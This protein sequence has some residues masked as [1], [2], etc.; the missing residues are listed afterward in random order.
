MR[1]IIFIA[2]LLPFFAT[3]QKQDAFVKLID[4]NGKQINGDAMVKGFEKTMQASST[5]SG[6]KNNIQFS[7]TMN[8]TGAAADLKK[9]MANGE[10]LMTGQ[11]TLL[12][13]VGGGGAPRPT[14]IIKMKKI[15]VISCTESMGCNN[16]ITTNC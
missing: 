11:V 14:Y 9:A 5:S 1:K 12:Q 2:V 13:L 6:G 16:T 3:A 4:V 10:L 15:K 8:I 7:F